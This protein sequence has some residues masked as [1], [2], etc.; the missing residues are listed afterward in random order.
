MSRVTFAG[1][2]AGSV[3]ISDG[4]NAATETVAATPQPAEP[5]VFIA[6]V[7]SSGAVSRFGGN[8][9]GKDFGN[10][11]QRENVAPRHTRWMRPAG[12][13]TEGGD[14][15]ACWLNYFDTLAAPFWASDAHCEVLR[16]TNGAFVKLRDSAI[17]DASTRGWVHKTSTTGTSIVYLFDFWNRAGA[18]Q[19]FAVRAYNAAGEVGPL[20]N[21]A[22]F[23]TPAPHAPSALT[24]TATNG[25]ALGAE[26]GGLTAPTITLA[27]DG[28]N[29]AV[30][31]TVTGTVAGAEGY[32]LY[33]SDADPAT[34]RGE[35]V[36]L[37]AD[38]GGALMEGSDLLLLRKTHR[39]PGR[40]WV[41]NRVADDSVGKVGIAPTL[42]TRGA[43][44]WWG[45]NPG[46]TYQWKP[47]DPADYPGA[48]S[49]YVEIEMEAGK[50]RTP[51][52][53]S[54]GGEAQNWYVAPKPGVT[55][56]VECWMRADRALAI[57][58]TLW[59]GL[60]GNAATV[61]AVDDAPATIVWGYNDNLT[62]SIE[63]SWQKKSFEFNID[64]AITDDGLFNMMFPVEGPGRYDFSGFRIF[65]A[66]TPYD[67]ITPA[68]L[69]R[70]EESGLSCLRPHGLVK[71]NGV[72]KAY[73]LHDM[74]V[75]S[76]RSTGL[77]AALLKAEQLG[78][79]LW[80]QHDILT[81][82]ELLGLVE[83]LFAP[84]GTSA[85]TDLRAALG[86]AT[87]WPTSLIVRWEFFNEAWNTMAEFYV[88]PALTDSVGGAARSSAEVYGA[89]CEWAAN[90]L[91]GS[92]H[93]P[94]GLSDDIWVL[95]GHAAS[96][97]GFGEDA[98]VFA[99]TF[100]RVSYAP[101]LGGWES[102]NGGAAQPETTTAY[103]EILRFPGAETPM[104]I[105]NWET[106]RAAAEAARG[107]PPLKWDVYEDQGGF[108]LPSS[109]VDDTPYD[110]TMKS[111]AGGAA[112]LDKYLAQFKAGCEI[113]AY[114][115]MNR[116]I[117]WSSHQFAHIG[118]AAYPDF[119]WI[120]LLHAECLGTM[121]DV[122]RVRGTARDATVNGEDYTQVPDVNAHVIEGDAGGFALVLV[123]R[124]L[125][126]SAL[127]PGDALYDAGD[128][129]TRAVRVRLPFLGASAHRLFTM[130]G[131]YDSHNF[132][133]VGDHPNAADL[134]ITETA[135]GA[136]D[137][138]DLAVTL[139][140]AA[141]RIYI[142]EGV[143]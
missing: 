36:Q 138:P 115:T 21:V 140:A 5:D 73:D 83:Y 77:H 33:M 75:G 54:F 61:T 64:G 9:V 121:R 76:R 10:R 50:S 19:W 90:V 120:K 46:E 94:A 117:N 109:G 59:G 112:L 26:T 139:P 23:T 12:A 105:A 16:M 62:W 37:E 81:E 2:P 14:R 110:R 116:G 8:A 131:D 127:D 101:Y 98:S 141:A 129:G 111:V 29:S 51:L 65:E 125:P 69:T 45:D 53:Y 3:T 134:T 123:N 122:V 49:H 107:G 55:Y 88:F 7:T 99:P 102:D 27:Q 52:T 1:F 58:P 126:Y 92:P 6:Q 86:R 72:G 133:A 44:E 114:F 41:T 84:D 34:H 68:E 132:H 82:A 43:G 130:N 103:D 106:W 31:I 47:H 32:A 28:A 15:V 87:P 93:W 80:L 11:L 17:V 118:D 91:K 74:I 38:G 48:P 60:E 56:R 18:Q 89:Y 30:T 142:F 42:V 25:K 96:G 39:H 57:H 20:S 24:K 97:F 85:W 35:W 71:S 143:Y 13:V 108:N 4:T 119:Q 70:Y 104:R 100:G 67:A 66:D 128:D 137:G 22:T 95:G 136:F 40:T 78:V 63:T 79:P 113:N 135:L 124:N